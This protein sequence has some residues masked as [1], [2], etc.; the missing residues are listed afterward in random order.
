MHKIKLKVYTNFKIT[1][2]EKIYLDDLL[3][4][5]AVEIFQYTGIRDKEGV[6]IYEH[7][8]VQFDDKLYWVIW[9]PE[10][11]RFILYRKRADRCYIGLHKNKQS[12]YKVLGNINENPQYAEEINTFN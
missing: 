6:E 12:R 4:D 9:E 3:E 10:R 11:S 1:H 2:P 7:D 8:V 5:P